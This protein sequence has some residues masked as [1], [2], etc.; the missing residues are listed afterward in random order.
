MQT[1]LEVEFLNNPLRTWLLALATGIAVY[2][3]LLIARR[4]VLRY[5]G[6]WSKRTSTHIDDLLQNVLSSTKVFFLL[7]VSL[8]A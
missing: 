1:Y 2:I 7:F 6:G 5:M 8:Y 3:G 4:L